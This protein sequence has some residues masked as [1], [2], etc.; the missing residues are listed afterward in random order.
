MELRLT[1]GECGSTAIEEQDGVA[2]GADPG[3]APMAVVFG[4]DGTILSTL[5]LSRGATC[6]CSP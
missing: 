4:G 1:E 3:G 5:R 6:R 2:V